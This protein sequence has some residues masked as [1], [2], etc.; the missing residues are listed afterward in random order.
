MPVGLSPTW[1]VKTASVGNLPTCDTLW[2]SKA[3]MWSNVM[4]SPSPSDVITWKDNPV[5]VPINTGGDKGTGSTR[6][7]DDAESSGGFTRWLVPVI[8]K[9]AQI[10]FVGNTISSPGGENTP[11]N[12]YLA[13]DGPTKD[14]GFPDPPVKVKRLF[15]IPLTDDVSYPP[16]DSFFID[17][18][19]IQMFSGHSYGYI[20]EMDTTPSLPTTGSV[21]FSLSASVYFGAAGA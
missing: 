3:I 9:N 4:L 1:Q 15:R 5:Y 17:N 6:M 16:S 8:F 21:T 2:S 19:N 11:F 10:H 12:I 14:G 18:L 13:R 7:S 20:F